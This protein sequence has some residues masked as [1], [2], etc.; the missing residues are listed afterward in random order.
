MQI[1]KSLTAI[2]AALMIVGI[3]APASAFDCGG[4]YDKPDPAT[5]S[6][7]LQ[8]LAVF[9]RCPTTATPKNPGS[10]PS[11]GPIWQKAGAG[12]CD[13]HHSLARKLHEDRELDQ[14]SKKPPQNK[15]NGVAGAS[16]DVANGKYLD[17]VDKLDSFVRDAY[18]S[19]LNTWEDPVNGFQTPTLAK[20]F[21]MGE[22]ETARGRVCKLTECP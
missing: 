2:G 14:D 12:S 22:V 7:N 17:A 4:T 10:W 3:S 18:K 19:R 1:R 11:D 15:N 16:G 13:V 6:N 9:L 5:I 21:L 20:M 8:G